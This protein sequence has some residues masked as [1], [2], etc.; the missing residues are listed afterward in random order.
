MTGP[1]RKLT[2]IVAALVCVIVAGAAGAIIRSTVFTITPGN[3][4]RLSGTGLYCQ[5][6]L[7][8][9]GVRSFVCGSTSGPRGSAVLRSYYLVINQTG[10]TV[11][12]VRDARNGTKIR[13]FLNR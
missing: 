5:N 12:R 9:T 4:A 10:V 7:S 3:Y 1:A 13:S 6:A 11:D 2:M 8:A